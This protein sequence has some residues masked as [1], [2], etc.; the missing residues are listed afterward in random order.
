MATA[1]NIGGE[2]REPGILGA[3]LR[4]LDAEQFEYGRD[5]QPAANVS[6]S[7]V[8]ADES[9]PYKAAT[10][11]EFCQRNGLQLV[12]YCTNETGQLISISW[13]NE[14]QRT[15]FSSLLVRTTRR[16]NWW[17][18]KFARLRRWREPA[19]LLIACLGPEGSGR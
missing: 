6:A 4:Y 5:E 1:M 18:A 19:G 11:H 14:Q 9:L 12:H 16:S 17:R 15:E 8:V 13:L 7:I 3:L 2:P 10:L